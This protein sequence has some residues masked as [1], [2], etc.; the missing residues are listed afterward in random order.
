[1]ELQGT[2][3]VRDD[4]DVPATKRRRSCAQ[5]A[6]YATYEE[7]KV[8]FPARRRARAHKE[9]QVG[10]TW[11]VENRTGSTTEGT[12][13]GAGRSEVA[14]VCRHGGHRTRLMSRGDASIR[15]LDVN[16]LTYRR[17]RTGPKS[18]EGLVWRRFG[19]IVPCHDAKK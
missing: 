14:G 17:H 4:R 18:V 16:P 5:Q 7:T 6:W 3:D 9:R 10:G 2:G 12:I 13:E 1:M 8:S 11:S 19:R 15:E